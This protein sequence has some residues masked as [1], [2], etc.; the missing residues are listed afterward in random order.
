MKLRSTFR[1]QKLKWLTALILIGAASFSPAATV[2]FNGQTYTVSTFTGSYDSNTLYFNTTYMPWYGSSSFAG[3]AAL[4]L[5]PQ[6]GFPNW[7]DS[8]S[9]YFAAGLVTQT[10]FYD[11]VECG[12]T[13]IMCGGPSVTYIDN[14]YNS[15]YVPGS[16]ASG[17]YDLSDTAVYAYV[18]QQVATNITSGAT[19]NSSGLGSTVNPAFDGGTLKVSAAGTVSADFTVSSRNGTIDQNGN[20]STWSGDIQDLTPGVLGKLTIIN[21]GAAGQGYVDLSGV[22]TYS[23][24]TEVD[25]GAVL[26]ISDPRSLGTGGLALVGSA[27]TPATLRTTANMTISAPVSVAGDPVF[28]VAPGTTL[29]VSSPITDGSMAGDVVVDGGGTLNLTADN[30]YTGPTTINAG[31]TLALT[32]NN[33]SISTSSAVTNNGILDLRNA[34]PAGVSF[35]GSYTQGST[36]ALRMAGAPGAFQKV[37]IAGA[38][39]LNGVLDLTAAQGNYAIGRYVL[40]E[41]SGGRSGTFSTFSNNLAGVTR[42]GYL[43]GYDANQVYLDLTPAADDTL[44]QVRRNASGLLSVINTQAAALQTALSYDC[45]VFDVNNVCVSAGGRYSYSAQDAIANQGGLVTLAYRPTSQTRVG[46]FVDQ[47]LDTKGSSTIS[48]RFTQ[49]T[50]GLFGNWMLNPDG[51]G[52]NVQGSAAFSSSDLT[53]KRLASATTEDGQGKSALTGQAY[54]LRLN[55]VDPL[56]RSVT[57]I[58]YVGVRSTRMAMGAYSEDT[59]SQTIWPVSY[60]KM[61]QD[62]F[63]VIAGSDISLRL[64]DKWTANVGVGVQQYLHYKMDHYTGVSNIPNVTSFNM[65]MGHKGDMLAMANAGAIYDVGKAQQIALTAYWQ[66]QASY[67]KGTTSLLATWSAGF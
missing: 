44:Q 41:A 30:T 6:L 7:W 32:G 14:H 11:P 64:M 4:S 16:A 5:G 18:P 12:L 61:V 47:P 53:V 62:S 56:T 26:R 43:L 22:N 24:G 19:L 15:T 23:G 13:H 9:P 27:T 3:D 54:S 37:S 21:S 38:A 51:H 55:Y 60:N 45:T 35:S 57:L 8:F 1:H 20:T 67:S 40:I 28:S 65:P 34:N 33:A 52:L 63:A 49:P 42:L 46:V 59:S 2:T 58:P 36:G 39:T 48:Q 10:P 17:W 66:Q 31:S 50:F 25:A 29:T